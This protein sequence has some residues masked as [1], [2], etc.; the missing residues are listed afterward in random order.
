MAMVPRLL[1]GSEYLVHDLLS[2]VIFNHDFVPEGR[3]GGPEA[4]DLS[5]LLQLQD[6]SPS[7]PSHGALLRD[8]CAQLPSVRGCYLTHL[9][10][11]EPSVLRSR[12]SYLGCTPCVSSQLLPELTG[13]VLP[14]DWA[15]LPLV[16]LYE[17]SGKEESG[18]RPVEKAPTNS[19]ESA[20]HC[21]QW[22]LVLE[23]WRE[24]ALKAVPPAAKLCRLACVFLCSSDLFLER[25]VQHYTWGLL[26]ALCR[27]TQQEAL[28]L[29]VPLPGLA[30]FHDLYSALLTQFEAVSFG[31][32]LFGCFL[33]LPL[34]RRFSVALRLA[35]F[36]E[37]VG[38]LRS[39]GVTLQQVRHHPSPCVNSASAFL[40]VRLGATQVNST[41]EAPG[42][43][44][45]GMLKS[46]IHQVGRTCENRLLCVR[47]EMTLCELWPRCSMCYV[48]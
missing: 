18:G 9:A 39:L 5:Q 4:A 40:L 31:N 44:G 42:A 30:S 36:G 46:D 27:P 16:S 48:L 43:V 38:L 37:H 15:F 47:F 13:P 45:V 23:T 29:G 35:V 22:L 21:L 7:H 12:D 28:D 2:T 24:G 41:I 20:T 10:H 17:R 26:H 19:I 32:P 33:L 11:L 6:I 3:C 8:A 34:Q 1:P 25:P 14:S